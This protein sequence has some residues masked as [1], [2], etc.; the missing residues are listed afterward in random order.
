MLFVIM[1]RGPFSRQRLQIL[2]T[3][4]YAQALDVAAAHVEDFPPEMDVLANF[5]ASVRSFEQAL[6]V[7]D[8]DE[9]V[10]VFTHGLIM[11]AL[12]WL[13]HHPSENTS[14]AAMGD[15]DRFRRSVLVP[16]CAILRAAKNGSGSIR[17]SPNVTIVHEEPERRY[18][19]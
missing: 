15:F 6:G 11:Q 12:L 8:A 2:S 4:M 1:L 5:I 7:R 19:G 10:V 16:N 9:T 17:L 13:Q 14:R 3:W 18:I